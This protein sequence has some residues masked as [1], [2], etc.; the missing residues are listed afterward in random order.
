MVVMGRVTAPYGIKGWVNILPDTET[1][2]SLF[3]YPVWWV[4]MPEGWRACQVE[5]ARV[6]G[7]HL[8]AKLQ[9]VDDRDQAFQLKGK[10][11]AVPREQ[12][13]EPEAGEYYW[14]DLIGLQVINLQNV[15]LGT[16]QGLFETGANDVM[17]VQGERERL[18]PFVAQVVQDVDLARKCMRVD[19]DAEF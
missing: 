10:L 11:V 8:V 12:L 18:I 1:L 15:A 16:I 17:V 2:D 4:A 7:D 13:P 14:A 19:W 3:G 9:G 6:Q 5:N